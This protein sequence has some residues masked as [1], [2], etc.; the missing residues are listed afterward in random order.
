[1]QRVYDILMKCS[2]KDIANCITR[3][4]TDRVKIIDNFKIIKYMFEVGNLEIA[5]FFM[6][7]ISEEYG[8]SPIFAFYMFLYDVEKE[9]FNEAFLYL[10]RPLK[11]KDIEGQPFM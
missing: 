5:N 7:K 9:N 8:N 1:M 4:D 2:S 10:D 6:N 3:T 11:D